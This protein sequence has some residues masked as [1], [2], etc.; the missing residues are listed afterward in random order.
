MKKMN[1]SIIILYKTMVIH[2][3]PSGRVNEPETLGL[4]DKMLLHQGFS[5]GNV[6]LPPGTHKPY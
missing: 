2:I 3:P 5:K 1:N 6:G 4:L